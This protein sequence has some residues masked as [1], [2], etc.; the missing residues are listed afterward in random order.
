[1][2][3]GLYVPVVSQCMVTNPYIRIP[4]HKEQMK[5]N[6]AESESL[7]KDFGCILAKG[8]VIVF[9]NALAFVLT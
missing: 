9:Y 1:M 5:S 7:R 3:S 8:K 4:M 2:T 6:A